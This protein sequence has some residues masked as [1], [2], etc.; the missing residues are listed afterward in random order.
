ML[1][2]TRGDLVEEALS[3]H[4]EFSVVS[5]FFLTPAAELA[6]LVL[7]A[8]HWLEQ[9]D[10]VYFHKI[11]CVLARRKLAQVGEV[12]DDRDVIFDLAHRLGLN[13]AFP[14]PDRKAYLEWLLEP[15]GLSFEEFAER[16]ILWGKMRYRKYEQE[17]FPTPS[18][19]VELLSSIMAHAGRPALPVYT[20]PPASTT[21][22]PLTLI[23]GCK[24]LPFFHSEGRQIPSLRRL[25]PGPMVDIHPDTMTDLLL[26]AGQTVAVV[27]P[28]GRADFSVHPDDSLDPSVIHAEH[29][30]WFPERP[31]PDHG[32]K[33]SCANLLF[34]HDK[35][36]PDSG[37]EALKCGI[38]RVERLS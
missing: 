25:H 34:G 29:A 9:D 24:V 19:R 15:S 14:W 21:D 10:I 17:G 26:A 22:Y 4:V 18:G 23:S 20:E 6:D 12:R 27:T 28:Y 11:W 33:E 37:A 8:A 38:C 13:E 31:G 35:F 16:G 2:A 30:W 36:D 5:D 3:R 1:T 32:W 7:P